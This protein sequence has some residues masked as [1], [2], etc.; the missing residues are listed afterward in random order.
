MLG[1]HFGMIQFGVMHADLLGLRLHA[2]ASILVS[3]CRE[4]N[5]VCIPATGTWKVKM[6]TQLEIYSAHFADFLNLNNLVCTARKF[7]TNSMRL[8][9]NRLHWPEFKAKAKNSAMITKFLLHLHVS[10]TLTAPDARF[11][12]ALL[13][14]LDQFYDVCTNQKIWLDDQ[15]VARIRTCREL[16]LFNYNKLSAGAAAAGVALFGMKPKYHALDH[17]MRTAM[18]SK[19]NP[20]AVWEFGSEDLG[21]RVG[22]VAAAT[23]PSSMSRRTLERW[24]LAFFSE[25][26]R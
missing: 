7:T 26:R 13:L 24:M 8:Y 18:D 2:N 21:G 20:G 17:I 16:I 23:H 22:K 9:T 5:P 4:G 10:C 6:N 14:G 15:D 1:F 3:L 25:T 12:K 11:R 19:L